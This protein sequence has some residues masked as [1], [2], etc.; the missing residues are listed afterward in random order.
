VAMVSCFTELGDHD[1][2]YVLGD[3][4]QYPI[5]ALPVAKV[6]GD[7]MAQAVAAGMKKAS[8]VVSNTLTKMQIRRLATESRMPEVS[9][10]TSSSEAMTWLL[11]GS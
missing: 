5:Q 8:S 10:F 3:I 7:L 2:W 11:K 1:P 4:S 6:H 9:F